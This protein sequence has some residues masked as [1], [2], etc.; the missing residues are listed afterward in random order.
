MELLPGYTLVKLTDT[1]I[2]QEKKM[3]ETGVIRHFG[4]PNPDPVKQQELLEDVYDILYRAYE[5][6]QMEAMEKDE[7]LS[8][9]EK[10]IEK[11]WEDVL[12]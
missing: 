10:E 6:I 7:K 3:G 1:E 5:R 2:V 4:N 9:E 12:N 8:D 11:L